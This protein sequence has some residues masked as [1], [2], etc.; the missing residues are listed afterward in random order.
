MAPVGMCAQP[1]PLNSPFG[2]T[3]PPNTVGWSYAPWSL[4]HVP[5][6]GDHTHYHWVHTHPPL[7]LTSNLYEPGTNELFTNIPQYSQ[8]KQTCEISTPNQPEYPL[9]L[10]AHPKSPACMDKSALAEVKHSG[11]WSSLD[12]RP[13]YH[14][15]PGK[16]QV[17]SSSTS[18]Q[19]SYSGVMTESVV[20]DRIHAPVGFTGRTIPRSP[21]QKGQEKQL[22]REALPIKQ[23]P[24]PVWE[25]TNEYQLTDPASSVLDIRGHVGDLPKAHSSFCGDQQPARERKS[26]CGCDDRGRMNLVEIPTKLTSE[27]RNPKEI[28][29]VPQN[30]KTNPGIRATDGERFTSNI[31]VPSGMQSI[32]SSNNQVQETAS[33]KHPTTARSAI[34]SRAN[35]PAEPVTPEQW[36]N[37][38]LRYDYL[39][40]QKMLLEG[41]LSSLPQRCSMNKVTIQKEEVN[42]TKSHRF[43]SVTRLR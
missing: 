8:V 33:Q 2:P 42:E 12:C 29:N 5:I 14:V 27:V 1:V 17:I 16:P 32:V 38:E 20:S 19:M 4:A 15:P 37:V 40:K 36:K 34:I 11:P 30:S 22:P 26:A 13:I 9:Q 6:R 7:P 25:H 28:T 23:A 35:L 21:L 18:E 3:V 41:Q 31:R 39:Q 10:G 43:L 24:D